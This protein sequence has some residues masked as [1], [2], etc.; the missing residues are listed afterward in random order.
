MRFVNNLDA[1]IDA[2]FGPTGRTWDRESVGGGSCVTPGNPYIL[3]CF[4]AHKVAL[5]AAHQ[6]H[7]DRII[8]R[9]AESFHDGR[10]I[11]R[12]HIVG[13]AATWRGISKATYRLRATNRAQN[14]QSHLI[15]RL[16]DVGLAGKVTVT[17]EQRADDEPI[18][19]NMVH[20]SSRTA[21]N[22]RAL[23]RRVE[24]HLRRARPPKP[25]PKTCRSP[26]II[27][28]IRKA[29]IA[30]LSNIPHERKQLACLRGFLADIL[31]GKDGDDRFWTFT[32]VEGG[33]HGAGHAVTRDKKQRRAAQVYCNFLK[34]KKLTPINLSRALKKT[35]EAILSEIEK[36]DRFF[37]GIPRG[38]PFT[39]DPV[40]GFTE[41]GF[42]RQVRAR[43]RSETMN[44]VYKCYRNF[45]NAKFAR[46]VTTK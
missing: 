1:E 40:T 3:H 7:L 15:S 45:A 18:R 19:D 33:T 27:K 42:A 34:G 13:H 28:L 17:I 41:C 24:V 43:A 4:P 46:C 6:D 12:V 38:N 5:T 29:Q 14:A 22:N 11:R 23:N 8:N 9:I 2:A 31:S 35:H 20:S 21:R 16:A 32:V 44:S 25:K 37:S 10:P 39:G 36:L 30:S 26:E